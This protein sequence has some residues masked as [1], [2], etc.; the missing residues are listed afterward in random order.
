[1]ISIYD[2]LKDCTTSCDNLIATGF[3]DNYKNCNECLKA[4]IEKHDAEVKK[5]AI[6]EFAEWLC[7]KYEVFERYT[8]YGDMKYHSKEELLDE[9]VLE[10]KRSR[11]NEQNRSD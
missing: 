7:N 1:M 11:K 2:Y 6:E 8:L 10:I 3:C 4:Q 5:A 9:F